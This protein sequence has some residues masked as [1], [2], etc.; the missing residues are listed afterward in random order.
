MHNHAATLSG[1]KHFYS[2]VFRPTVLGK[3]HITSEKC[4]SC[5]LS[6]KW[7]E[8]NIFSTL[9][10]TFAVTK[11]F[12]ICQS[13]MNILFTF[14]FPWILL[15]LN[16]I[17]DLCY[18]RLFP[19]GQQVHPFLLLFITMFAFFWWIFRSLPITNEILCIY[20]PNISDCPHSFIL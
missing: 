15:K 14:L 7:H 16:E 9:S 20:I 17:L 8:N 13:D 2:H 12:N 11:M 1:N 10:S 4:I 6:V 5:T 19:L 3:C 18:L